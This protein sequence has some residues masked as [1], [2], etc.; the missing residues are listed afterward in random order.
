MAVGVTP[1]RPRRTPQRSPGTAATSQ[2]RS[3]AAKI[4][5][6]T[7]ASTARLPD[8][9]AFGVTLPSQTVIDWSVSGS[10]PWPSVDAL[11]AGSGLIPTGPVAF[12]T[13][14]ETHHF[15]PR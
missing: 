3:A 15:S 4:V 12:R 8:L 6:L 9:T 1:K 7:G 5:V 11:A 13:Q 2:V 10:G 14:S